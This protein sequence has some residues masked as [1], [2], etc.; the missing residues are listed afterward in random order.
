[1]GQKSELTNK[2]AVE[3]LSGASLDENDY[4]EFISRLYQ[5][6]DGTQ[7]ALGDTV[8]RI[9]SEGYEQIVK[10]VQFTTDHLKQTVKVFGS[11]SLAENYL[12]EILKSADKTKENRTLYSN[13]E[14]IKLFTNPKSFKNISISDVEKEIERIHKLATE[15]FEIIKNNNYMEFTKDELEKLKSIF[16]SGHTNHIFEHEMKEF[17]GDILLKEPLF[18]TMDN[19]DVY[20]GE[21]YFKV[22]G[23]DIEESIA[24]QYFEVGDVYNFSNPSSA[25]EY[26]F[27]NVK[28]Y[29]EE[30]LYE[31]INHWSY[32]RVSV[33]NIAQFLN[34][35]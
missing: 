4:P 21:T 19:V 12:K 3:T 25:H 22:K 24:V 35:K 2:E 32:T 29:T 6:E 28:Q 8:Y 17:F 30:Q 26:V 31:A 27:R 33:E 18:S 1:L 9:K 20:E 15:A 5:L 34:K 13:L 14:N 7:V 11:F 10:G 16:N 23:A